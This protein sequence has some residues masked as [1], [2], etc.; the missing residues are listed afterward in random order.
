MNK[1]ERMLTNL[2]NI[3]V[4]SISTDDKVENQNFIVNKRQISFKEL[5]GERKVN[6]SKGYM[7]TE[8]FETAQ[9]ITIGGRGATDIYSDVE[10][11]DKDNNLVK[12][13]IGGRNIDPFKIEWNDEYIL[14]PYIIK[15]NEF[16]AAF[17]DEEK[18]I[19]L[20]NLNLN[21]SEVEEGKN[22]SEKLKVRIA[23]G[24]I[25]NPN[26]AEYLFNFYDD[27]TNRE[28]ESK[29]IKEY[30]KSWY[31]YHR[32]RTP[33]ILQTPKIVCRRL[34][35]DPS[36][37]IDNIGY[38][39]KDSVISMIPNNNFNELIMDIEKILDSKV[40]IISGL[41]YILSYLN[42]EL[43][44]KVLDEK[45]AKKQGGY[46]NISGKMLKKVIIPYPNT[47]TIKELKNKLSL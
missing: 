14:F 32:P 29:N 8:I 30:N 44:Q 39:P 19:D 25:K 17:Y 13:F 20:L 31:A 16:I 42:S 35:K 2:R 45:L 1:K 12:K 28:F 24:T 21:F 43:F 23:N 47:L 15:N 9:G 4:K 3:I 40:E 26:V 27:L 10:E 46:A 22:K 38:L 18:N 41:Y 34:M 33:M 37:A 36:F 11:I 5:F 7:L 6:T